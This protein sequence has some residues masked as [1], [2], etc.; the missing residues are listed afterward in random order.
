MQPINC[1]KL[2]YGACAV[3]CLSTAMGSFFRTSGTSRLSFMK[4]GAFYD[5]D[6]GADPD[7]PLSKIESFYDREKLVEYINTLL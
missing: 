6:R 1:F 7:F 4:N 2:R 3:L 5:I